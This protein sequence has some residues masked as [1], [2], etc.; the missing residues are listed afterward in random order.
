MLTTLTASGT[1]VS[2]I[3]L[4]LQHSTHIQISV[5]AFLIQNGLKQG[6]V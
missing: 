1:P 2:L 5:D 3:K 6:N 4:N